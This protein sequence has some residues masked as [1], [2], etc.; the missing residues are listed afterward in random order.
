MWYSA[1][2]CIITFC[3]SLLAVPFATE[4]QPLAKMPR[5]GVL[6]LGTP[7]HPGFDALRH[8]LQELGYVEGQTID[9]E[10]RWA[11]FTFERLPALA[12]ELSVSRS[13]SW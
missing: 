8:G 5:I 2:G 13:I 7:P 1:C 4:A 9:F 6:V 11:E 12:A 3:L 10:I